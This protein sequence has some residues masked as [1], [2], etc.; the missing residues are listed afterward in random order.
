MSLEQRSTNQV[1]PSLND[2]LRQE[3]TSELLKGRENLSGNESVRSAQDMGA[4]K[5]LP[6]GDMQGK[7][8][9]PAGNYTFINKGKEL[10]QD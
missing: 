3:E 10:N 4:I 9:T 6:A 2:A 8:H 1:D 5:S 7:T